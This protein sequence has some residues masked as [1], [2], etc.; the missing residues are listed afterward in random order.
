MTRTTTP[1]EVSTTDRTAT[2]QLGDSGGDR[3]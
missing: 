1:T 3:P 2:D